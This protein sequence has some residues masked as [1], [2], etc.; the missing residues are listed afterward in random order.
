MYISRHGLMFFVCTLGYLKGSKALTNTERRRMSHLMQFIK[1]CIIK[2]LI[3]CHF[4]N[5][6]QLFLQIPSIHLLLLDLSLPVYLSFPVLYLSFYVIFSAFFNT[7]TQ[8][9]HSVTAT[10]LSITTHCIVH[11]RLVS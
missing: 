11:L 3:I 2:T 9:F 7:V 5:V 4:K 1:K 8:I 10:Y 6:T